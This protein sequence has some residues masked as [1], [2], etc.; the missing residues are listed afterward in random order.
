MRDLEQEYFEVVQRRMLSCGG[1]FIDVLC[2][3]SEQGISM[4]RVGD[5]PRARKTNTLISP[6]CVLVSLHR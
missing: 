2:K 4:V 5:A 1:C 3:Y 6:G